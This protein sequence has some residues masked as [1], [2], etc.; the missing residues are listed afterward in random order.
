[1]SPNKEDWE[2]EGGRVSDCAVNRGSAASSEGDIRQFTLSSDLFLRLSSIT[3]GRP[4]KGSAEFINR[5]GEKKGKGG[6]IPAQWA[7]D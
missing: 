7:H 3:L 2:G 1:M 4:S 6:R 5:P